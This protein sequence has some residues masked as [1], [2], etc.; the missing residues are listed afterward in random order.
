MT[1]DRIDELEKDIRLSMWTASVDEEQELIYLARLG[2]WARDV[3]INAVKEGLVNTNSDFCS[4]KIEATCSFCEPFES[5]LDALPVENH[6][7]TEDYIEPQEE[8]KHYC[9]YGD[10]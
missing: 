6:T 8:P 5:A 1:K 7:V 4:H 10:E 3:G 9:E 2:L